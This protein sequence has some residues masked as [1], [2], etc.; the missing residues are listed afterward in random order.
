MTIK[1]SGIISLADVQNEFGGNAPIS[2]NEYYRNG[3]YTTNNNGAVPT[4][5]FV[6]INQFYGASKYAPGAMYLTSSTGFVLPPTSGNTIYFYCIGGGGGGGGGSS[7][8]TYGYGAGGGGGSGGNSYGAFSASPGDSIWVTVGGGGGAG[9]ARDGPYSGGASGGAGGASVI[10]RNGAVQVIAFG[11]GG[12]VVAQYGYTQTMVYLGSGRN[13]DR[14]GYD[15]GMSSSVTPGGALGGISGGSYMQGSDAGQYG[16]NGVWWAVGGYGG[17]GFW[18]SWNG[19]TGTY[20]RGAFGS[21]GIGYYNGYGS[22]RN[23]TSGTGYGAG[24][25]GGGAMVNANSSVFSG[26]AGVQGAVL[27][28]W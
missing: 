9:G 20:S 24:G 11:G 21:G 2:V 10:Y 1:R 3:G 25:A 15:T 13:G 27:I 17:R 4:A 7:R 6:S 19:S 23:A 12:G 5:G 22:A 16:Q 8:I 18:P 28:W 14:W 26:S